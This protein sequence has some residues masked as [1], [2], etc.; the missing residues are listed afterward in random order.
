MLVERGIITR[1]DDQRVWVATE[2]QP[3]GGCGQQGHCGQ[4]ALLPNRTLA[5]IAALSSSRLSVETCAVGDHVEIV[6]RDHTLLFA[7]ALLYGVPLTAILVC[8]WVLAPYGDMPLALGL[9]TAAVAIILAMPP[10]R[11]RYALEERCL[12]LLWR[13]LPGA[14]DTTVEPAG[15][16]E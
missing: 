15:N 16:A 6:L 5:P 8:V 10:L 9:V 3:C 1:V 7:V 12:P 11:R 2:S 4:R 13:K 14:I